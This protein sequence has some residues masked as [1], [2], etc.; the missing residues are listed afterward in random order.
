MTI[1]IKV[2]NLKKILITGARSGIASRVIDKIKNDYYIYVTVKTDKELQSVKEKYKDYSNIECFKL[3]ITSKDKEKLKN[4][5]IDILLNNAAICYG[6]SI[7]DIPID[8]VRENYEVNVF[9]SFEVVQIV[10]KNM[11][12][13]NHGK[14][15][16][17][18]S[19]SAIMPLRFMGVYASTKASISTLSRTLKK[20]IKLI[21]KNIKICMIEPGFYYTGFN[22]VMFQNKYDYDTYFKNKIKKLR[23]NDNLISNYIEYKKLDTVVNKIVEVIN[24]NNVK[25]VY[26]MPL[27]QAFIAKIYNLFS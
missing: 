15:I 18:S 12:K 10:L 16:I 11:L 23:R 13:Q 21:N 26:R 1:L 19:L 14:I 6:G 4:L 17:M 3:D 27:S 25:S 22:Q 7:S 2:I 5:K 20:E 9:S 24:K 8:K